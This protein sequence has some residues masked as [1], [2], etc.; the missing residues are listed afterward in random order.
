MASAAAGSTARAGLRQMGLMNSAVA[1]SPSRWE[2]ALAGLL[3]ANLGATLLANGGYGARFEGFTAFGTALLLAVYCASRV[4]ARE[5]SRRLHPAGWL[6][7]PFVAYAGFHVAWLTPV[8][9]LGQRD[10]SLWVQMAVVF[11]VVLNGLPSRAPR[12][13]LFFTLVAVAVVGVLLGCHQ[14]F[15]EPGW[16]IAGP[17]RPGEQSGRATGPFSVANSF[18]GLLILLLPAVAARAVRPAANA[19]ARVWWAW[20]GLVLLAGLVLSISRG[21]WLALALSAAVSPLLAGRLPWRRRAAWAVGIGLFVLATGWLVGRGVPAVRER[22]AQLISD[23]GERTRPLMWAGAARLWLDAPLLGNGAGSYNLL[24]ERHRP[25]GFRDEPLWAHNEYLNLLADYGLIG[26]LL[27]GGAAVAL[28]VAAWRRGGGRPWAAGGWGLGLL[29][30]ALHL[31]L[32]FHL[33][34]PGLALVAA[35]AAGLAVV[36]VWPNVPPVGSPAEGARWVWIVVAGLGLLGWFAVERPRAAAEARRGTAR[37]ALDGLSAVLPSDAAY[38]RVVPAA[39]QAL[40][41]ATRVHAGNA[42][43]WSDL[44]YATSLQAFVEP[45]RAAELGREAEAA[46]DAA[47]RL[48]PVAGEFHARRGEARDLQ[49]R[50]AEAGEDFAQAVRL[51]PADA[52][53]WYRYA[54]HLAR[55]NAG[56]D[57]AQA[58]V[59]FCLRLDPWFSAGLR[60]RERLKRPTRP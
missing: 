7:L 60:L 19:T 12:R 46:A 20:V 35:A 29:A 53:M 21:A 2:W 58:A 48:C 39:R 15:A 34:I 9:W 5:G 49:D 16:R 56:R 6:P 22:F 32:E 37:A 43:A 41:E 45:A 18:A 24:F 59:G 4:V 36:R 47:L 31:S 30:F 44:A 3:A 52:A 10:L 26:G 27:A 23:G 25:E 42:Q 57:A 14:V 8:P 38:A 51:S 28:A 1:P 17:A 13:W 33:K 55:R 54:E 50:W 40:V 11:W